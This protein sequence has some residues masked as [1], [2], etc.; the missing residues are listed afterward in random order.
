VNSDIT[1]LFVKE[2][3]RRRGIASQLLQKAIQNAKKRKV[4]E[5]HVTTRE[6]NNT[7]IRFYEKLGFKKEG[8]L[9]E[10]NP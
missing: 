1:S 5:I 8:I 9:F 7:A 10:T 2:G 6:D 4:R 3:Y